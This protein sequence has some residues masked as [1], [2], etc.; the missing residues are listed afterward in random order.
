MREEERIQEETN[1][2]SYA[3]G[4]LS[5]HPAHG[6]SPPP[7]VGGKT[8]ANTICTGPRSNKKRREGNVHWQLIPVTSISPYLQSGSPAPSS[9]SI[10]KR[11]AYRSFYRAGSEV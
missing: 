4:D 6:E 2:S 9:M 5:V 1:P 7:V 8:C 3:L 10:S 11:S